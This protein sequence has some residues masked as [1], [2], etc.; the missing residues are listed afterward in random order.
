MIVEKHRELQ[1]TIKEL[2][3]YVTTFR[4]FESALKSMNRLPFFLKAWRSCDERVGYDCHMSADPDE[5]NELQYVYEETLELR[6]SLGLSIKGII[7]G[8]C[9]WSARR[10]FFRCRNIILRNI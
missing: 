8:K 7:R 1:T 9:G 5:I 2:T 6:A 10:P 4:S 3:E